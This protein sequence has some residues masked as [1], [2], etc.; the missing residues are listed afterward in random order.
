MDPYK[1]NSQHS[2]CSYSVGLISD[3]GSKDN[4]A[5]DN[6]SKDGGS[7]DSSSKDCWSKDQPA[8]Y[9]EIKTSLLII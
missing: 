9:V 5:K 6:G 3:N 2:S 8:E 7:K 4:G 1:E